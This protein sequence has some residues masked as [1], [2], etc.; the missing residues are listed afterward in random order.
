MTKKLKRETL[1]AI[2]IFLLIFNLLSLPV[3]LII[4]FDITFPKAQTLLAS[5]LEHGLNFLGIETK[6][7]E[8]ILLLADPKMPQIVID[9]DCIGWKS[10]YMFFALVLATPISGKV[11]NLKNKIKNFFQ[12]TKLKAL[13]IGIPILFAIN[14]LRILTT[15]LIGHYFGV[16]YF[17]IAHTILWRE[18]LIFAVVLIWLLWLKKKK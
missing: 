13:V 1:L 5:F 11:K 12:K 9:A 8:F 3:W 10:V 2:A 14:F 15:I 4:Y 18:G 16:S 17:N 7:E 6:R